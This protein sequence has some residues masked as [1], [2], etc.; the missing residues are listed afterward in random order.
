M[1]FTYFLFASLQRWHSAV[2][3]TQTP[4]VNMSAA[5]AKADAVKEEME[6]AEQRVDQ[7]RVC[8]PIV[9]SPSF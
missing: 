3:Q 7:A 2:R 4:G 6:E 8:L 5:S 9:K 1:F